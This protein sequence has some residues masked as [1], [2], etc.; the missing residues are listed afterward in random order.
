MRGFGKT[1]LGALLALAS[2]SAAA[3]GFDPPDHQPTKT[4]FGGSRVPS[5]VP[6]PYDPRAYTPAPAPEDT[7]KQPQFV[8]PGATEG[9]DAN[10]A[11]LPPQMALPGQR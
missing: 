4:I 6:I 10:G 5:E 11:S 9:R 7:F 2:A 8:S 3:Q 1:T